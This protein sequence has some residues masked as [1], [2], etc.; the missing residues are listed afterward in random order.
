MTMTSKLVY[1]RGFGP[2]APEVYRSVGPY[3][4]RGVGTD[5]AIAGLE[6][7][8]RQDVDPATVACVVL[9]PV[10]GE[11][12]FIVMPDDFPARLRELC[13]RHGILYVDDEVQSGVG[14]TGRGVGDRALGRRARPARLRASRSAAAC[15]SRR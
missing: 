4:Y 1:K 9:E 11:G 8:F 2:F 3:P 15:R 13:G 14:R 6:L 12:G 7:L 10:Q 5:E